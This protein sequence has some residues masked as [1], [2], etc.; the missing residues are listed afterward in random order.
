MYFYT[1]YRYKLNL[2]T[3]LTDQESC[4]NV[5]ILSNQL[6][7]TRHMIVESD[8]CEKVTCIGGVLLSNVAS[9]ARDGDSGVQ[10]SDDIV[11][12]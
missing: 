6:S 2:H 4:I 9:A 3:T 1:I 12:E 8:L 11:L 10:V 5:E 7:H